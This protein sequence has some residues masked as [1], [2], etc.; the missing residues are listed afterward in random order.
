[1]STVIRGGANY[2]YYAGDAERIDFAFGAAWVIGRG[3]VQRIDAASNRITATVP[4]PGVLSIAAG[5]GGLWVIDETGLIELNPKTA[6]AVA[7][8]P[9]PSSGESVVVAGGRVWVSHHIGGQDSYDGG[10][11]G[12]DPS[13]LAIVRSLRVGDTVRLVAAGGWIWFYGP[14]LEHLDRLDPASGGIERT[15]VWVFRGSVLPGFGSLWITYQGGGRVSQVDLHTGRLV[16]TWSMAR[17]Q[18][19]ATGPGF[20]CIPA[21]RSVR[22]FSFGLGRNDAWQIDPNT[23]VK[24]GVRSP[25]YP[26]SA[27]GF[28]SF[29]TLKGHAIVRSASLAAA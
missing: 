8:V 15:R 17:A 22:C 21:H 26:P 23:G 20:W 3:V 24:R 16:R 25:A 29:W 5:A 11:W 4:V 27:F 19:P 18:S 14:N 6:R 12:I 1:M 2:G 28:G 9:L 13:S 10:I 7:T